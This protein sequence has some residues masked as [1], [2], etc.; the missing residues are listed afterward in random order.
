MSYFC[1][2]SMYRKQQYLNKIY[3]LCFTF[4]LSASVTTFIEQEQQGA[5]NNKVNNI[6]H[7]YFNKIYDSYFKNII[8]HKFIEQEQQGAKNN[9]V[10]PL[11]RWVMGSIP[12]VCSEHLWE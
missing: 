1:R 12:Y 11:Y 6:K 3:V 8:K 7:Q 10:L 4:T 2:D 5:K 9:K